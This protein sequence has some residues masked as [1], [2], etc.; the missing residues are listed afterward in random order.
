MYKVIIVDD[1]PI[2]V[3]G[4]KLGIEWANWNCE[5]AGTASNGLVGLELMRKIK[6]DIL[7]SD[8]WTDLQW[9]QQLSL[10]IPILKCVY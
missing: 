10:S 5:I 1:E 4:L 2:I 9:L 3:E 8:I 6:P 7:I